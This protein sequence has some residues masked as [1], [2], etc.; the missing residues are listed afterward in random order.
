MIIYNENSLNRDLVDFF[1]YRSKASNKKRHGAY[2][3]N[4]FASTQKGRFSRG[5]EIFSEDH[6][7]SHHYEVPT[8]LQ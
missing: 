7:D 3:E 2:A 5:K 1:P 8:Q 6:T 4:L